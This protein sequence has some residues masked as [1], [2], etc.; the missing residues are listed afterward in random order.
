[1]LPI[2]IKLGPLTIH[3][4]GL[5]AALGFTA[6]LLST[7]YYADKEGISSETILNLAIYNIIAWIIGARLFYVIGMWNQFQQN[8]LDIIMIQNGGLVFLGG[9]I[10]GLAAIFFVAWRNRL[11][12]WKIL[13]AATPGSLLGFSIGRIGCLLNGCCF[14]L[15]T[16]LPWGIKFPFGALAYFYF[17]NEALQPTQLLDIIGLFIVFVI[18]VFIYQRRKFS[19]QVFFWGIILYSIERFLTELLRYSPLHWLGLTPSQWIVIPLIII[20]LLGLW[21]I[22]RG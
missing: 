14:G 9:L 12:V 21:W 3:S 22:K 16:T 1:M 17:P 20:G 2:L 13:D 10:F 18:L 5:L 4:Y 15:P 7:V 8:P 19:G 6:G 11:P